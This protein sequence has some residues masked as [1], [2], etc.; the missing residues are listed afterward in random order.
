MCSKNRSIGRATA[1]RS[2][3]SVSSKMTKPADGPMFP[4]RPADF[5]FR[6]SDGQPAGRFSEFPALRSRTFAFYRVAD[7]FT[8]VYQNFNHNILTTLLV[9]Q[10]KL[11]IA[12]LVRLLTALLGPKQN[13]TPPNCFN[14]NQT[15]SGCTYTLPRNLPVT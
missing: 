9:L 2:A 11:Q 8:A 14:A 13:T 1:G 10:C 5:I 7:A 12:A 4:R 15:T 6:E 3:G